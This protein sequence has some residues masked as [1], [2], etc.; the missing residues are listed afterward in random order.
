M[1]N[2]ETLI[3]YRRFDSWQ[4]AQQFSEILEKVGIV[5]KLEEYS[6]NENVLMFS[7]E[8]EFL[9]KVHQ[10]DFELADKLVLQATEISEMDIDPNHYLFGFSDEEL[11]EIL[12]KPYEW[13]EIDRMLAPKLLKNRGYDLKK[14][15]IESKKEKYVKPNTKNEKAP[16]ALIIAGYCFAFLGGWLGLAIAWNLMY[17]KTTLPNGEKIFTYSENCQNH[18]ARILLLALVMCVISLVILI[19]RLNNEF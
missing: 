13:G 4:N 3:P 9:V 17:R 2:K 19:I 1:Q 10:E 8:K 7:S 16:P 18:G 11:M 5:Y 15:D 14:L 12:V 6:K